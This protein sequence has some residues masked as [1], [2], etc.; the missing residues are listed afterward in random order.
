MYFD[1]YFGYLSLSTVFVCV[2]RQECSDERIYISHQDEHW[3]C[4][5]V[6]KCAARYDN[7]NFRDV[8]DGYQ[9]KWCRSLVNCSDI[10]C[11]VNLQFAL[12]I[13]QCDLLFVAFLLSMEYEHEIIVL[14]RKSQHACKSTLK[15]SLRCSPQ[16]A[17]SCSEQSL[18]PSDCQTR[19]LWQNARNFC[20]HSLSCERSMHL[21]LRRI[22][23]VEDIPFYV[24]CLGQINP[25]SSK[26]KGGPNPPPDRTPLGENPS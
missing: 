26:T 12:T 18:R 19:Q 11:F 13:T 23:L 1:V 5:D 21:V 25:P 2:F 24:K 10:R 3:A 16:A 14:Y 17:R 22:R 6:R 4:D 15:Y 7:D 9:L 8:V 20:P